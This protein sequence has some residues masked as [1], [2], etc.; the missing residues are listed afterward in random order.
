M[1]TCAMMVLLVGF[2]L[3]MLQ[4]WMRMEARRQRARDAQDRREPD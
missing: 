2:G 1:I 3:L 4:G